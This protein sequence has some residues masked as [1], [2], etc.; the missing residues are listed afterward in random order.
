[1]SHCYKMSIFVFSFFFFFTSAI[2]ED[3]KNEKNVANVSLLRP[4][5]NT[6]IDR[7]SIYIPFLL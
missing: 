7:L 6:E 3:N 4:Q 2:T 5:S 1:M